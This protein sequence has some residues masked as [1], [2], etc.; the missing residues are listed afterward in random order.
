[1]QESRTGLYSWFAVGEPQNSPE[2]GLCLRICPL[3]LVFGIL[4]ISLGENPALRE[5]ATRRQE[6]KTPKANG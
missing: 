3:L 1:M 4:A 6:K 2:I 5:L